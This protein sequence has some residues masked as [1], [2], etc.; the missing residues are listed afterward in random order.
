MNSSVTMKGP[1]VSPNLVRWG[2][3]FAGTLMSL[4][5]FAL[6][7]SLWV[8]ISYSDADGSGW[9]SGN[10]PWFLGATAVTSLFLAGL[11]SGFLSGVRGAGA[12]LLNGLTAWGLLFVTSVVT[13]VPGLTAIT[14]NLGSGLG[15]GT[16]TIGGSIASSGGGFSAESAVWTT[17]WSL[18][19]GALVAA[20]GGIAGG[21]VKR[22][23]KIADAAVQGAT[24]EDRKHEYM[25]YPNERVNPVVTRRVDSE[26]VSA[27][28]R[29]QTRP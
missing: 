4:G 27:R 11:L 28:L 25:V 10:L 29:D 6:V 21:A 16:N 3:V 2:A 1:A 17:F 15:N 22:S 19:V 5:F 26:R 20:L 24:D 8:A 9:I 12:G 14:T 7:S 23:P 13:V 18:L